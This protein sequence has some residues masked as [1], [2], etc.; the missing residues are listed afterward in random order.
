NIL[1]VIA[2]LTDQIGT[3]RQPHHVGT[4]ITDHAHPHRL[5]FT[6]ARNISHG[7]NIRRLAPG[8]APLRGHTYISRAIRILD[9]TVYLL[10]L[11][12]LGAHVDVVTGLRHDRFDLTDR[13]FICGLSRAWRGCSSEHGD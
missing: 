8:S 13:I 3:P 1:G 6:A 9:G 11:R 12:V 4:Y 7:A 5:E 10:L 2:L